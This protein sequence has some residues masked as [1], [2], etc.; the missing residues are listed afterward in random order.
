V[1]EREERA[2]RLLT[3][4]GRTNYHLTWEE[5][6]RV[7]GWVGDYAEKKWKELHL[8]LDNADRF[9]AASLAKLLSVHN[10]EGF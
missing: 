1:T 9:D 2:K 7:T 4:L 8:L 10:P 6:L 3:A 5:F